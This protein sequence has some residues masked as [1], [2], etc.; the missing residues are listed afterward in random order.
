VRVAM[1]KTA[2]QIVIAVSDQGN[3]V[4]E[5]ALEEIFQPFVRSKEAQTAHGYG[6]G[7]ALAKQIIEAHDGHIGANNNPTHLGLTVEVTL[8]FATKPIN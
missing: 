4:D 1:R 6:I 8:P 3:G 2:Q 5:H 7:L